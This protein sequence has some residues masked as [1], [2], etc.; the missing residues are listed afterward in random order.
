MF[1]K[2]EVTKPF[3]DAA[4]RLLVNEIFY[5]IQGEGP[6]AGCPAVFIRLS[7]C[8]LRC[9][10]C[11]TEFESGKEMAV[12]DVIEIV[13]TLTKG[14][15]CHLIVIT[16]GEPL[17]QNVVPVI[18]H[19]NKNGYRVSVET[20]GTVWADE[21]KRVFAVRPAHVNRIVCSPKTSGI[22]QF[23]IPYID[24]WK[25][26]V[27]VDTVGSDGLPIKSTQQVKGDLINHPIYRPLHHPSPIYVQP[28]D[29]QEPVRNAANVA[30]CRDLAMRHGYRLS[31]Q[32][33]KIVGVP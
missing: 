7:K 24:A 1:G 26:V 22:N 14:N 4:G 10:F 18:E 30:L 28:M 27:S 31:L 11:D 3:R 29:E 20:A 5:T 8:N 12:G 9:Y 32:V 23:I 25:Y 16:G 17:L 6:D 2:N 15:N 13:R 21:F 19:L 33:H